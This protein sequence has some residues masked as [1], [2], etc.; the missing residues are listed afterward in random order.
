MEARVD[1]LT[2]LCAVCVNEMVHTISL[3]PQMAVEQV[4]VMWTRKV[5]YIRKSASERCQDFARVEFC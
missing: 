5:S 1:L 3:E 2:S 4:L